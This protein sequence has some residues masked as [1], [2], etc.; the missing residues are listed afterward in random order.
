MPRHV[1]GGAVNQPVSVTTDQLRTLVGQWSET[2]WAIGV[3]PA[4]DP[5]DRGVAL[6]PGSLRWWTPRA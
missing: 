6:L 5:L 2:A 4:A 3:N 1:A